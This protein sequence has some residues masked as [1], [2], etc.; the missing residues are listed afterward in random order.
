MKLPTIIRLDYFHF[1]PV[2]SLYI[3]KLLLIHTANK[4][5]IAV[6]LSLPLSGTSLAVH[7]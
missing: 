3:L 5:R 1:F 2:F 7:D 4:F 6:F